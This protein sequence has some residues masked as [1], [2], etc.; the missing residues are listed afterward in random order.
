MRK[1]MLG[2]TALLLACASAGCIVEDAAEQAVYDLI[3]R[4]ILDA[5]GNLP[6]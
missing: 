5:L 2:I 3:V 4:S 6:A 1:V